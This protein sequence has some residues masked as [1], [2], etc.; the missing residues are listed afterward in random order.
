MNRHTLHTPQQ[1]LAV[2][3]RHELQ[4][5]DKRT[6]ELIDR[7]VQMNLIPQAG[8][9]FLMQAPFGDVAPISQLYCGLFRNNFI[10]AAN[11]TAADIPLVMGEFVDYDEPTRPLW[12]RSYESGTYHNFDNKAVFTPNKEATVYGSFIVT[13]SVKGANTGLLLSV[14][15]FSTA[16][17]LSVGLE[18]KLICGI[19][20]VPTNSV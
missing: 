1:G 5:F 4:I 15:R 8:I 20:Y 10:A 7:E 11:T 2:G 19:T 9:D 17:P 12:D 6:G 14:V 13:N 16:K 3:F 18:A